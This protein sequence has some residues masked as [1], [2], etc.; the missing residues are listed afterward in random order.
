[1]ALIDDV[2]LRA[3]VK[4]TD[5]D[6]LLASIIAAV[7]D[8]ADGE[9][10]V[11]Y[12]KATDE[13]VYFDGGKTLKLPHVNVSNVTIYT[14]QNQAGATPEWELV[15]A[16]DYVVY[17][18]GIIIKKGGEFL[19][20]LKSVKVV[21]NGGYEQA[22]Y[23]TSLK[24]RLIKQIAFEFRR[25]NDPGLSSVTYPDGTINKFTMDRWLPDVQDE[26]NRRRRIKV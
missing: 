3:D 24:D 23:P 10:G 16:E 8:L 13:I 21:Y 11:K 6:T 9:M 14:D 17:A 2:K 22:S 12:S 20:G 25:R 5:Y 15:D 26:L 7:F 1:M 4:S 19:R 18:N